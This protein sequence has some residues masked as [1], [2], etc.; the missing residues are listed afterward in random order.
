MAPI[1]IAWTEQRLHVHH[2]SQRDALYVGPALSSCLEKAWLGRR[3]EWVVGEQGQRRD[4]LVDGEAQSLAALSQRLLIGRTEVI[5]DVDENKGLIQEGKAA[6]ALEQEGPSTTSPSLGPIQHR[7]C[8]KPSYV[9][10]VNLAA[11]IDPTTNK[12]QVV[13]ILR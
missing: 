7:T 8:V 3:T 4:L 10:F 6:G 13:G 12:A 2:A 5:P 11:A 1:I 9:G